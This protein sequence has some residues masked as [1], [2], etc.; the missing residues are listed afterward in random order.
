MDPVEAM[1]STF[2]EGLHR[3]PPD[4][5]L[6]VA[7]AGAEHIGV[8]V[9]G[10]Y[11]V[12][13]EQRRLRP[14]PGSARDDA[15][16]VDST[17]P[18][19][20]FRT[21]EPQETA[22]GD[23]PGLLVPLLDGSERLGVLEASFGGSAAHPHRRTALLATL[24]A[25][26]LV[27]KFSYGDVITR[28]RRAKSMR[29]AAEIQW[30]LLPPLTL[31]TPSVT[32]SGM[33]EPCYE[34]GGDAFDYAL[35]GRTAH[36]LLVDAMGHG[37]DSSLVS[38]L[39]LG[40]YRNQRRGGAG[41]LDTCQHMDEAVAD[42]FGPDRFATAHIAEL[43]LDAGTLRW[44]NAGH[45]PP[46][47]IRDGRVAGCL[48]APPSLPL[49]LASEGALKVEEQQLQPGDGILWFSD[50]LVEARSPE[51]EFFG[52]E[53]LG[54]LF[55]RALASGLQ[56]AEVVRRLVH[57]TLEH[58]GQALQDDATLLYLVWHDGA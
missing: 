12:D 56:A 49:G 23:R 15:Y 8:R 24:V 4:A 28:T 38:S 36:V 19:R 3:A 40:A 45:P 20:V 17:L 33:L 18:G 10:V 22:A 32:V 44:V 55:T 51:G 29:L 27:S 58:Q 57:A 46:M 13:L 42:R 50:G 14:L 31:T 26:M 9:E 2:A 1:L 48:D 30:E 37:L 47:L 34:I 39:V 6:E 16:D 53:R 11:L 43:D 54:D 25:N 21:S 41:L 52:E 7:R 35:N 5:L